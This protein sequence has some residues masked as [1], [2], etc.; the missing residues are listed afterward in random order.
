MHRFRSRWVPAGIVAGCLV[1]GAVHAQNPRDETGALAGS[2]TIGPALES[3][4]MRFSLYSD[5]RRKVPKPSEYSHEREIAN[6]VVYLESL[7]E[8][9]EPTRVADPVHYVMEQRDS[10]FVPHV[11]PIV[12]GSTVEFPN[13]DLV[14]H[15]VFSFSK[16]AVFDL[17][18]YA[19]DKSKEVRF[20]SP[21]QVKVF[22]HIHSDMSALILVL[23]NPFFAT[24]DGA[25]GYRIDGIPAGDY[26]VV[27]WH[28][29]TRPVAETVHIEPGKT[30]HI[31]F[32][33]PLA[34]VNRAD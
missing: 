29:R 7:A 31:D 17:G 3:N 8:T 25:G 19:R 2:V 26:R 34:E 32:T 18:R 20:D 23:P 12:V 1:A 33:I 4:K 9:T 15:N 24:P 10:T 27:A 21:G 13:R 30:R 14:F 6:V 5:L 22:C 11:L 28:E 16:P